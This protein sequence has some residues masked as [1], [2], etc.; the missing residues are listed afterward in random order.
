MLGGLTCAQQG[1]QQLVV[2]ADGRDT[3][4]EHATREEC[5]EPAGVFV[6]ANEQRTSETGTVPAR[7]SWTHLQRR[8][9][10]EGGRRMGRPKGRQDGLDPTANQMSKFFFSNRRLSCNIEV[11]AGKPDVRLTC[12]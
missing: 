9:P 8:R 1:C 3:H 4:V 5:R 2:M 10:L 12:P 7:L 11:G 6:K